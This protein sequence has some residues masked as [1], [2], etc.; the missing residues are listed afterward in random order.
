[1]LFLIRRLLRRITPKS[2]AKIGLFI[3][4]L[5]LFMLALILL[6]DG[7]KQL[8][9]F[10]R[11]YLDV[12]NAANALGFGWLFAYVVMSG[13]PVAAITLTLL[14][15]GTLDR[16]QAFAMIN[17]SR[18]GASFIV[19]FVGFLYSL[20]RKE[21]RA[22]MSTGMLSL[23]VTQTTYIP[24]LLLGG[25]LLGTG[26]LDK[27]QLTHAVQIASVFDW[28]FDPISAF[29]LSFLPR[30]GVFILG[31]L[32][33]M[34]SFSLIDRSLPEINLEDTGFRG[35]ARIL[36]KPL[37]TFLL[38]AAV[39]TITM[40]VSLSVSI[41]V[42]LSMRGY[43]RRENIIPYV[44]GANITTFIDTLI[45]AILLGNPDAFT[46][47]L[48]E[49]LSISLVS[50]IVIGLFYMRYER[51]ILR[52]EENLSKKRTALMVYMF[53]IVSIPIFLMLY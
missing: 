28:V 13:S 21:R 51:A 49:M 53:G 2:L 9:P 11:N 8:G 25:W 14:D 29:L 7:A 3:F 12:N 45:A 1:M 38:G 34:G 43:V 24:A 35:M 32:V 37:F 52:I 31:F 19:L 18:L 6:K 42:P 10:V 33:M 39:T 50:L 47:V 27:F 41:L 16:L 36:Y 40:S 30:W 15:V 44:M 20:R 46:V 48:L 4:S 17:G 26:W 22:S 5:F 23:L